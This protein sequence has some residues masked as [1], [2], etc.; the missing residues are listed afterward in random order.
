MQTYDSLDS[1]GFAV[2]LCCKICSQAL[3]EFSCFT[4]CRFTIAFTIK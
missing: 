3:T 1:A 2:V 4:I